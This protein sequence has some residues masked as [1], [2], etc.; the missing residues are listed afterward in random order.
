[1]DSGYE[2]INLFDFYRDQAHLWVNL[3]HSAQAGVISL[4][5]QYISN[6]VILII[7]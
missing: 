2:P 1:M 5:G 3:L 4:T 6:E 7:P